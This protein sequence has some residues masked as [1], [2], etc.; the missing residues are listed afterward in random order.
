MRRVRVA[1]ER[2]V[3]SASGPWGAAGE[4]AQTRA[5]LIL[6]KE[7]LETDLILAPVAVSDD[8]ASVM[9]KAGHQR[10]ACCCCLC[11][12]R[13]SAAGAAAVSYYLE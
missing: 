11:L 6:P 7:E 3:L 5:A 13:A 9:H 1:S 8:L 2:A 10:P 12:L 4:A